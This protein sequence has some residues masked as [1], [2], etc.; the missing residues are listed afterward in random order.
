[1][2]FF[3]LLISAYS[4]LLFY[5]AFAWRK[6][7]TP[8]SKGV[9]LKV[10]VLVPFRNEELHL[11][12]LIQSFRQLIYPKEL[13]DFIFVDDHS[14]DGSF[15]LLEQILSDFPYPYK[16]LKL[17]DEKGGKKEAIME[18]VNCSHADVIL[19]TDADCQ[20]NSDWVSEMQSAFNSPAIHLVSGS[21]VFE[22]NN[23]QE[24]IFQMEFAPLIGVGGVSIWLGKPTMANGA[25]LAFKRNTFLSLDAFNNN[26]HI[27]TGDDVFLLQKM[28][29]HYPGG[30]KFQKS[31]VVTTKAPSNVS[32]FFHQRIRWASKWKAVAER[33]NKLPALMVWFF[34]FLYLIG[35]F[36]FINQIHYAMAFLLLFIKSIGEF[37]FIYSILKSQHQKF[38][39]LSF[40]FLQ[41]FYSFYVVLFGLLANFAGYQWK[42]RSYGKHER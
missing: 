5:M 19:T 26:L 10:T 35:L 15:G 30:I 12:R 2:I 32:T 28:S 9:P 39:S 40:C 3:L 21:V 34:H 38:S 29:Q 8:I 1:M 14:D 31:S 22:A 23:F 7:A 16:L 24:R 11:K 13:I 6:I 33:K 25:N 17:A 18:G 27:P 36:T 41:V 4:C 42:G 20:V 37:A